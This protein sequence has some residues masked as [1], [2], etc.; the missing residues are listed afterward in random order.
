MV[1]GVASTAAGTEKGENGCRVYCIGD[2]RE[3][4][5]EEKVLNEESGDIPKRIMNKTEEQEIRE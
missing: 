3:S 4:K 5:S 1:P 2:P